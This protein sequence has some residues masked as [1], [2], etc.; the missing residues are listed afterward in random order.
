M[1]KKTDLLLIRSF[2]GPLVVTFF[3]ALFVLDMQFLWK[4]VDDMIGK[5]LEW[6]IIL[7]L[8]FYASASMVPLA[9]PLA[10][11]LSAI[12]TFGNLGENFELTAF[13]SS[14]VSLFRVMLP[15]IITAVVISGSA[16]IFSNNVLPI[17]NLK[18]G[19][20]LYDIREQ[21]PAFNLQ[22]GIFYN[23]ISNYS[24]RIM[25][26]DPDGKTIKRIMIY[27]HT[28]GR[29]NDDVIIADKGE[30]YVTADKRYLV[31]KLFDGYQYQEMA[32]ADKQAKEQVRIHFEEFEKKLDMSEFSLSRTDESFFKDHY[33]MLSIGQLEEAIDSLDIAKE[34][35]RFMLSTYTMSSFNFRRFDMDSLRTLYGDSEPMD[36]KTA[37]L[38]YAKAKHNAKQVKEFAAIA[39]RDYDNQLSWLVKHQI[40]WHRKFTLSIACLILFFIGAP[41]GA[42]IR[43][44]GLGLPLVFA[45]GFFIIFH[46][47][48]MLSEKSV[49]KMVLDPFTGMWMSSAILLPVGILLTYQA[50]NDSA[51]LNLSWYIDGI[52]N[53]FKKAKKDE[54]VNSSE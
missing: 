40:E 18:F 7:E 52:R 34:E 23:G 50:M 2:A 3:I 19:S 11:L 25:E 13:K 8:L 37:P 47:T 28:R 21:K 36:I 45:V 35:K 46:V 9:L 1:L 6:Y 48:G 54:R 4:Y 43:R 27:D 41:L 20:L 10:V 29:G 5:G 22:E 14:G 49:K 51:V 38:V 15:L 12:M 16:F 30:M 32:S 44:G 26:K 24:I 39:R 33:T 31:L 42:I 17:A 53:Y